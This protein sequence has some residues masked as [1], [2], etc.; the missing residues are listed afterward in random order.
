MHAKSLTIE[1]LSVAIEK[2]EVI[3]D[4]S[5]TIRKGELRLLMDPNAAG[6]STLAYALAGHPNYRVTS[7]EIKIGSQKLNDLPTEERARLGF[8]LAF[9]YPVGIEGISLFDLLRE[10]ARVQ[11][12]SGTARELLGLGGRLARAVGLENKILG[13]ELN[14]ELSGG[15]KKRTEILQAL[16]LQPVFAVFDESDSGLDVDGL[17]LFGEAVGGL[18]KGGTGVLVISHYPRI[19][20]YLKPDFVHVMV[21]GKIVE[22]GGVSLAK[23]IEKG[24]YESYGQKES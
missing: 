6:K 5:L 1:R 2:K 13:K 16:A 12:W 3:K 19:L 15:E 21:G 14:F 24:G 10:T 4:L 9:Q 20:K 22:S 17:K 11:G 18:I 23:K 8:F 7:G